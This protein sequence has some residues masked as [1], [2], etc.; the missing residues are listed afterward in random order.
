MPTPDYAKEEHL[1]SIITEQDIAQATDDSRSE[2]LIIDDDILDDH[3]AF[4]EGRV[5][6]YLVEYDLT[7]VENNPPAVIIWAVSFIAAYTLMQRAD[8]KT[9]EDVRESYQEVLRWLSDVQEGQ[10]TVPGLDSY[11]STFVGFGDTSTMII[12]RIPHSDSIPG[13]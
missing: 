4:A 6:S 2:Q 13:T 10:A 8:L 3:L 5:E 9:S 7:E 11:D 1:K 12:D